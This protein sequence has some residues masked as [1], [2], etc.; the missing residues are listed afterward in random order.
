[1]DC[2]NDKI[3]LI[4]HSS[5]SSFCMLCVRSLKTIKIRL[6]SYS[7]FVNFLYIM[8]TDS[9]CGEVDE[10]REERLRKE[11]NVI[12]VKEKETNEEKQT[13][14]VNLCCCLHILVMAPH[15]D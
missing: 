2:D 10:V 12:D 5:L 6:T 1:M 9:E 4:S 13:R 11:E 15:I 3:R 14:L 8:C 7:S